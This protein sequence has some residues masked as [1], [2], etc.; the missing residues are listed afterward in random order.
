[1]IYICMKHIILFES[2]DSDSGLNF[3]LRSTVDGYIKLKNDDPSIPGNSENEI[4]KLIITDPK[5]YFN[6]RLNDAKDGEN[7]F[8]LDSDNILR[9]RIGGK[10][11]SGRPGGVTHIMVRVPDGFDVVRFENGL[12]NI[13]HSM[14]RKSDVERVFKEVESLIIECIGSGSD[15]SAELKYGE[16]TDYGKDII[17]FIE[18]IMNKIGREETKNLLTRIIQGL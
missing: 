12:S 14:T 13:R 15:S 11:F 16:D 10:D 3:N 4:D 5:E 7:R 1:M 8:S 18:P 9:V 6:Y 2:F 17:E